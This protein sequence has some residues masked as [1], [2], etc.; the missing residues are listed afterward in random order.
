MYT[1]TPLSAVERLSARKKYKGGCSRAADRARKKV[2]KRTQ[3]MEEGN[4]TLDFKQS[5]KEQCAGQVWNDPELLRGIRT[6][7]SLLPEADELA[8]ISERRQMDQSIA[9]N[10]T[11]QE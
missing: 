5:C 1:H 6:Y 7:V 2:Q 3:K 4:K 8:F 10:A 9:R 11:A